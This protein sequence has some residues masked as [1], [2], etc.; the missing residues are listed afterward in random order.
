MKIDPRKQGV[1][2]FMSHRGYVRFRCAQC[3][4]K[5]L[6]HTYRFETVNEK[7]QNF[8]FPRNCLLH[9]IIAQDRFHC[10]M[11]RWQ[12]QLVPR[13]QAERAR[14]VMIRLGQLVRPMVGVRDGGS[15][16][17]A[18][19]CLVVRVA[20][21]I[22]W[23][24]TPIAQYTRHS[25]GP[26]CFCRRSSHWMRFSFYATT[27]GTMTG[28][29]WKP[30]LSLRCTPSLTLQ[31]LLA[32]GPDGRQQCL[33][34]QWSA[35]LTTLCK[36]TSVVQPPLPKRVRLIEWTFVFVFVDAALYVVFVPYISLCCGGCGSCP[37]HVSPAHIDAFIA[38]GTGSD[39]S[40]VFASLFCCVWPA[41]GIPS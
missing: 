23:S 36:T 37:F 41:A 22:A 9:D 25:E 29:S 39:A 30:Y 27:N 18:L 8:N 38:L 16:R 34:K 31:G 7:Q 10:N 2:T 5:T 3:G 19:A 17:K 6:N 33:W 11:K 32:T 14:S 1:Q 20:L 26:P 13:I 40:F 21:G 4:S 15:K 12:T 28:S 24:T 35:Q